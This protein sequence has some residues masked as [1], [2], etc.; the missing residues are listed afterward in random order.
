MPVRVTQDDLATVGYQS[1]AELRQA[2]SLY[3]KALED[4]AAISASELEAMGKPEGI[5]RPSAPNDLV[6]S[7]ASS[8]DGFTVDPPR[9]P[10]SPPP[11]ED[12]T[13]WQVPKRLLSQRIIREGKSAEFLGAQQANPDLAVFVQGMPDSGLWNDDEEALAILAA[14]FGEELTGQLMQRP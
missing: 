10:G 12:D 7:C 14:I 3:L 11:A 13:R 5:P 2:V 8:R 4:H 6:Y 9:M 1:G